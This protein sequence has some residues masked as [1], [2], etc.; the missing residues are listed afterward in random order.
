M[1]T[2]V[3]PTATPG[4]PSDV[5]APA[6]TD[7]GPPGGELR[8]RR[9]G[10][11]ELVAA[12]ALSGTIGVFVVES[13]QSPFTVVFFRCLF[14]ALALAV[15]C[16]VRGWF[17]A[18]GFT[19]GRLALAAFGGVC[20][21]FN[22]VFLFASYEMTSITLATV[23]YH[24]QPFVVVALGAVVFRE[25]VRDKVGWIVLAFAGLV[26]ATEM[27]TGLQGGGGARYWLGVLSALAAAV[28]YGAATIVAKR[29]TG[30]RPQLTAL[31]QVLV[32][33]PLLLPFAR[34]DELGGLGADWLW[35]V[36][37]GFLHT[38]VLYALL[39]ASYQKLSTPAIAVLSFVYPVVAIVVDRIVYG[40]RIS[41][42]QVVGVALILLGG[43][44]VN[45]SR[46]RRGR[47]DRQGASR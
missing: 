25:Q 9:R 22:W 47:P 41:L 5:P 36:G 30:V 23:V 33:I 4:P 2:T 14:G 28:L 3:T 12:M 16:L 8:A 1:T 35:L 38:G 7:A 13:G 45:Y 43:L 46:G 11:A 20:I 42:V 10:T 26:L 19:P 21:V 17:S 24:T 37:L 40:T 39:Y 44:G 6:P 27:W 15:Y 31:V 32:G 34:F 29:L 18:T